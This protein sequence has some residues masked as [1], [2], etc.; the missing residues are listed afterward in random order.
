[1]KMTRIL[2][3]VGLLASAQWRSPDAA[4][5]V[6][7]EGGHGG[8]PYS[9][10]FVTLGKTLA[11]ALQRSEGANSEL[12]KKWHF[13]ARQFAQAV[14]VVRVVSEE[15]AQV[16]LRGYEVDAI[17][18]PALSEILVNRTRWREADLHQ[19]LQLVLHEYFGILG[20]E[21]DHFLAS[22]DFA[23]QVS[24]WT[25]DLLKNKKSENFMANFFYGRCISIPALD[26]SVTCNADSTRF[27]QAQSCAQNQAQGK[28]RLSGN[29]ECAIS[30]ASYSPK[31][32][33]SPM[34]LRYCEVLVI[35]K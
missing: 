25:Q 9:L 7:N 15:G 16:V 10:E 19:R 5:A 29:S 17:N 21:Q 35:M 22:V 8:D 12:F 34:G 13:T 1:M 20:V 26:D 33:T 31:V 11:E 27:A 32:S 30:S 24:D 4:G 18:K 6:G 14:G 23:E 28:C 3:L 2:I